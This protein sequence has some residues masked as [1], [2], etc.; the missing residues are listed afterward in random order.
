VGGG[1]G[2]GDNR[3]RERRG[4]RN[5]MAASFRCVYEGGGEAAGGLWWERQGCNVGQQQKQGPLQQ[6]APLLYGL[7]VVGVTLPLR[8]RRRGVDYV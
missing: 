7:G 6:D 3:K 2:E 8:G 1:G 4:E 5:M